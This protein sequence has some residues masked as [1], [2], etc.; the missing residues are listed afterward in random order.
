MWNKESSGEIQSPVLLAAS[1]FRTSA[2]PLPYRPDY[3]EETFRK[4]GSPFMTLN[5]GTRC[6]APCSH[7][8]GRLH[9]SPSPDGVV[10]GTCPTSFF[11]TI[12]LPR[13]LQF[14]WS[15]F[16]NLWVSL[17]PRSSGVDSSH[18]FYAQV[19]YWMPPRLPTEGF[20]Y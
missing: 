11:L 16:F 5:D 18:K 12:P 1:R 20:L 13:S 4:R 14:Q 9:T 6:T 8:S 3:D 7:L 15:V 10:D 2:L 19:C 17:L